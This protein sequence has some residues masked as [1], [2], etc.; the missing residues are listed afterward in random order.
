MLSKLGRQTPE[1][2]A[3]VLFEECEWKALY[4]YTHKTRKAPARPPTLGDALKWAAQLGGFL[5]RRSDGHPGPV[6]L[7]RGL[8]RLEDIT[9]AWLLFNP[10]KLVGNA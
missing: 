4:C 5:A 3:D 8:R 2:P 7:W 10:N 6:V 9:D 1:L